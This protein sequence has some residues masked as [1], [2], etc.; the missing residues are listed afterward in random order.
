VGA[1]NGRVSIETLTD[2]GVVMSDARLFT[3]ELSVQ[4]AGGRPYRIQH[5]ALVPNAQTVRIIRGA[6]FPALI[7]P[8]LPGGLGIF[9]ER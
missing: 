1:P 9:W 6:S 2:T 5:A 7:D 8:A 3:F 4:P